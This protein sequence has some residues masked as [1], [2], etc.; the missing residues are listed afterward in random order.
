M[1]LG[2][3]RYLSKCHSE[4]LRRIILDNVEAVPLRLALFASKQ[5][6]LMQ[7]RCYREVQSM[8]RE[9]LLRGEGFS[10]QRRFYLTEKGRLE[11]C[12]RRAPT[13]TAK[14]PSGKTVVISN[15]AE[16]LNRKPKNV[17]EAERQ[18]WLKRT[19]QRSRA[20][21]KPPATLPHSGRS[22]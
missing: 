8:V 21:N 17:F 2:E 13:R 16:I 11:Q 5:S 9:G 1:T 15:D 4:Q 18:A 12:Q 7:H 3:K 20:E 19:Q 10:H 14:A 6:G 22:Q